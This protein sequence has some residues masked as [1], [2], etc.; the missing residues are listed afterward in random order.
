MGRPAHNRKLN[1]VKVQELASLGVSQADI[2]QHQGVAQPSVWEFLHRTQ[3]ETTMID[4]FRENRPRLLA[5]IQAKSLALQERILDSFE[6]EGVLD[7]LTSQQKSGLLFATNAVM[8]TN[9]DKERLETGQST[10]NQS[11][12]TTMLGTSVKGLY[13]PAPPK[14]A[15]STRRQA[16]TQPPQA[17]EQAASESVG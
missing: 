10:S 8:G 7:L 9:Y 4:R 11:I 17:T 16:S 14:P 13:A 6:R 3:T 1:P 12:M 5:K 15:K 2:A